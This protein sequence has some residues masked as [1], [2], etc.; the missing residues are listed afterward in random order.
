MS[1]KNIIRWNL[2]H[3]IDK[4]LLFW[5]CKQEAVVFRYIRLDCEKESYGRTVATWTKTGEACSRTGRAVFGTSACHNTNGERG[6]KTTV[7]TSWT[8]IVDSHAPFSATGARTKVLAEVQR[9]AVWNPAG[10]LAGSQRRGTS[11]SG[12]CFRH[13]ERVQSSGSR[14]RGRR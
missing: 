13:H 6:R 4:A 11:S 3:W 12:G 2:L 7:F 14:V 8:A 9:W 10:R 5:R 1:G